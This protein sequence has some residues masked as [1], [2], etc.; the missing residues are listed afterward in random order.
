MKR[1]ITISALS[2]A[3]LGIGNTAFATGPDTVKAQE[4][5]RQQSS[6]YEKIGDIV[7]TQYGFSMDNGKLATA[8]TKKGGKYYVIIGQQ[9][10]TNH[11]TIE[12]EMYK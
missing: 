11:Q 7:I 1:F 12:A 3:L 6:S 8:V 10:E 9:G 4:I 2:L 5:T